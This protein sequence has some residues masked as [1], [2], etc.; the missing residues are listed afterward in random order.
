MFLSWGPLL[1]FYDNEFVGLPRF[2]VVKDQDHGNCSQDQDQDQD[3]DQEYGSRSK[4]S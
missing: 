2:I 1:L 4:G 3:L